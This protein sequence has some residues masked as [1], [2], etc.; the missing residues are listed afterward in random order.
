MIK[1]GSISSDIISILRDIGYGSCAI[2]V[3]ELEVARRTKVDSSVVSA[4]L[5]KMVEVGVLRISDAM[6]GPKGGRIYALTSTG[7]KKRLVFK[8]K[9]NATSNN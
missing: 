6:V 3:A 4:V 9:I 1:E 8:F 5:S 7:Q 2:I